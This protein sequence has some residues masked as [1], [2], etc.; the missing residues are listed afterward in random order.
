[1]HFLG[2]KT[3]PHHPVTKELW[4]ALASEAHRGWGTTGCVPGALTLTWLLHPAL[5]GYLL[6]GMSNSSRPAV[7]FR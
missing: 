2:L 5:L 4:G 6:I 1:M 3:H 7:I